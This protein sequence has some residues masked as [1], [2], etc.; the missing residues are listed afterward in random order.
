MF[1][2]RKGQDHSLLQ[3][4]MYMIIFIIIIFIGLGEFLGVASSVNNESANVGYSGWFFSNWIT[5]IVI[6]VI[7][8]VFW[9]IYRG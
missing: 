8:W 5:I 6:I 4:I 9:M 2:N 1:N 3:I 7:L